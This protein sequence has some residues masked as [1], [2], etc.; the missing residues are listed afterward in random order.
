MSDELRLESRVTVV[1]G[2]GWGILLDWHVPSCASAHFNVAI[3]IF[4]DKLAAVRC[5][6]QHGI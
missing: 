6:T 2:R 1:T 4:A 5:L 3:H